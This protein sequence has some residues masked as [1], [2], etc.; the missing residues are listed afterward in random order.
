MGL[1]QLRLMGCDTVDNT[2]S[3]KIDVLLCGLGIE[4][5]HAS[6][7]TGVLT[8]ERLGDCV[9]GKIEVLPWAWGA[10]VSV[11]LGRMVVPTWGEID[12]NVLSSRSDV[13]TCGRSAVSDG[14]N[15]LLMVLISWRY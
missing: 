11:A 13:P 10:G 6:D 2:P 8:T 7:K 1:T 5:K 4:G 9:D 14:S 3:F 12:A 15:W